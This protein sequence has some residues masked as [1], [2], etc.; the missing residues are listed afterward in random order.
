MVRLNSPFYL[1]TFW[2]P[3]LRFLPLLREPG[4]MRSKLELLP[5]FRV[6]QSGSRTQPERLPLLVLQRATEPL[7]HAAHSLLS[8]AL[9][10]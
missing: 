10:Y 6:L 8:E 3:I 7:Q 4:E 1:F 2:P 5:F 9:G